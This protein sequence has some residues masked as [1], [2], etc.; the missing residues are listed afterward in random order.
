MICCV[1]I[2]RR[3]VGQR[4]RHWGFKVV[5]SESCS[6]TKHF[7]RMSESPRPSLAG[8][9]LEMVRLCHS[10][11]L[12][13]IDSSFFL[14]FL[15]RSPL[16]RQKEMKYK[17]DKKK[18]SV[19]NHSLLWYSTHMWGFGNVSRLC[20]AHTRAQGCYLPK[21]G[22]RLSSEGTQ[23]SNANNELCPPLEHLVTSKSAFSEYACGK[24]AYPGK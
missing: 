7:P 1:D 11:S 2:A 4:R 10:Y 23:I 6:N 9:G 8:S 15:L 19:D 14:S 12:G 24:K 17:E 22:D 13:F 16:R 18:W 20:E 3:M 5:M 21:S